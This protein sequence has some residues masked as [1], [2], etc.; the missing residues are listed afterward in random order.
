MTSLLYD[1]IV[2]WSGGDELMWVDKYRPRSLKSVI[3]QQGDKSS[4]RK[5]LRSVCSISQCALFGALSTAY[6]YMCYMMQC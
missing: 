4:A 2:V 1:I 6:N 5:L 3:G